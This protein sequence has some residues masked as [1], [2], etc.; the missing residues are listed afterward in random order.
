MFETAGRMTRF[1]LEVHIDFREARHFEGDEV[2]VCGSIKVRFNPSDT[3]D[4]P[5][6]IA[7]FHAMANL[8]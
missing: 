4:D 1:I 3:L 6:T 2:G 7:R 5:L 8:R